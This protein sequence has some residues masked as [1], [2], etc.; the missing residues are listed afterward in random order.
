MKRHHKKAQTASVE[1]TSEQS[2]YEAIVAIQNAQEAYAF[3]RDLCTPAEL[4][5]MKDRW[6]VVKPLMEDQSY[7]EIYDQTGVS[8]TTI[9]RV[10]R[11]INEGYSG[12]EQIYQRLKGQDDDEKFTNNDR[13]PEE[14]AS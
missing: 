4:Q 6:M 1:L 12:Y 14:G 10:A 8:L 13:G 7:R 2:L 11:F 5:A 9:G 3:L